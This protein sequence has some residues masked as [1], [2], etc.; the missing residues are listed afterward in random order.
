MAWVGSMASTVGARNSEGIIDVLAIAIKLREKIWLIILIAFV[1]VGAT[2]VYVFAVPPVYTAWTRLVVDPNVRKPFDDSSAPSVLGNEALAVD[3]QLLIASSAAV[4]KPVV[5]E[6]GLA[7]DPEFVDVEAGS[8][9]DERE[10]EAVK[11]LGKAV[12]V[13][14]E[15]AT[16]VISVGVK[17]QGARKSADLS[18]AIAN[19]YMREQRQFQ[20]DHSQQ[21][22][23]QIDGRLSGLRERLRQADEKVQQFRAS[24]RLQGSAD[25]TLLVGQELSGLNVQLV[26]ARAAF[27]GANAANVEIQRYLKREI[28]P[29]ALGNITNSPRM[30]QLLEEYSRTVKEEASFSTTLLPQHPSVQRLKSQVARL[31]DLIRDEVTAIGE[32]KKVELDVARQRVENIERQMETLRNSSNAGEQEMIELRELEAEAQSTRAVY[33]NVLGRA[34]QVA[35][36]EQ[37]TMPVARIISAAQPADAP[38]WPK[39][40]ILLGLAG[41]LGLGLGVIVVV[42]QEVWNQ[43]RNFMASSAVV[44]R[45]AS[46][47]ELLEF[48]SATSGGTQAPPLLSLFSDPQLP[49]GARR[50]Q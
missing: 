36:L 43:L 23:E 5:Q 10:A 29:T 9:P 33:E 12:T 6:Y 15:G 1:V 18:L 20:L 25:G 41:I 37:V 45:Q 35:N 22:A 38:S 21:L 4:L 24:K 48:S 16:Y 7:S 39:K 50:A 8:S 19:A 17:S 31:S 32:G 11:N 34:K 30:V 49:E 47:H 26:E 27:A 42:W 3:T 14:R 28:D 2:A 44:R 40:K 46:D 13:S